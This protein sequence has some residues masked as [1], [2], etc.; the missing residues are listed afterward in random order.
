MAVPSPA[1]PEKSKALAG[2]GKRSTLFYSL[3]SCAA[4]AGVLLL[5]MYGLHVPG[6]NPAE[7][8]IMDWSVRTAG[9]SL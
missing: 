1:A 2:A 4:F 3:A 5:L 9:P 7:K 8:L 6:L